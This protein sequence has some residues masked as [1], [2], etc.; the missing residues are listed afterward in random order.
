MTILEIILIIAIIALIAFFLYYFF[1]G[2]GGRVSIS[3]PMESRVDMY[4]DRRF[5]LL[6]DEYS[7]ITKPKL[8]AF[9]AEKDP[10]LSEEEGKAERLKI[11]RD[12]MT[13]TMAEMEKRLD[14][15]EAESQ[16]D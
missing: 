9:K 8:R 4:L 1:R 11:F 15:L 14:V 12:E 5:D 13:A 7:L 3:R 10:Y 2:S 16:A 6:M